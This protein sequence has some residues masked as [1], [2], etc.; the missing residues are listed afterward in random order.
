MTITESTY[1]PVIRWKGAEKMALR[2]LHPE[3]K[4]SV[5]PIIEFVPKDFWGSS[6]HAAINTVGREI[7]ENWGWKNPVILDPHLLG[8]RVAAQNIRIVINALKERNVKSALVTDVT[9]SADYQESVALALSTT[10][11]L[12]LCLR[13]TSIHLRAAGINK[14]IQDLLDQLERQSNEVHLILDFQHISN[15]GINY[16]PTLIS[17]PFLNEWRSLTTLGG[18]FPIDLSELDPH[19][20]HILQRG[21]WESWCLLRQQSDLRPAFGDYTVQHPFFKDREGEGFNFS[22]S[23]RYTCYD[24]YHVLRG[25]GRKKKGKGPGCEQWLGE[26]ALIRDQ[27]QFSGVG[28]SW[29]DDFIDQKSRENRNPGSIKD[30]LAVGINHH[31]TLV[32]NQIVE[33]NTLIKARR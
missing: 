16:R 7:A 25:E 15:D 3:I 26:A 27:T 8:D 18:S 29:G 22:P 17:L 31:I 32:A 23:I 21:E 24:G 19:E 9:R 12:E 13:I 5:M 28:Y 4:Q 2:Q 11:G 10:K 6:E 30:W 33:A 14:A 1:V 20:E